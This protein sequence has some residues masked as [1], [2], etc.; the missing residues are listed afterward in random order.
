MDSQAIKLPGASTPQPLSIPFFTRE[1]SQSSVHAPVVLH[2]ANDLPWQDPY[3]PTIFLP[4]YKYL[5][6]QYYAE[7]MD[8]RMDVICRRYGYTHRKFVCV[9]LTYVLPRDFA[10]HVLFGFLLI[11]GMRDTVETLRHYAMRCGEIKY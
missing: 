1:I 6:F 3:L 7:A 9:L 10:R 2:Y 11:F 8:E 4:Y 5:W